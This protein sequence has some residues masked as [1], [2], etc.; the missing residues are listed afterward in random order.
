MTYLQLLHRFL[1]IN[2]IHRSFFL[3]ID[4]E[5][6]NK[7]INSSRDLINLFTTQF[8]WGETKEGSKFWSNILFKWSNLVG[9]ERCKKFNDN[10]NIR[11]INELYKL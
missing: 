3:Y 7:Y 10:V 5:R 1:K 8:Y 11:I 6:Y 9:E 2:G 4:K